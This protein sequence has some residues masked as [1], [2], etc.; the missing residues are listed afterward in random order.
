[1][2]AGASTD[3]WC[4]QRT[5]KSCGPDIPTL[6]SGATRKRCHPRRQE[7]PVSGASTKETVRTIA[8]GMPGGSG[9]TVVTNLCAFLL[10]TQGCGRACRPAFPAPS[11][12][13]KGF[14]KTR[15]ADF[16]CEN[17]EVWLG[18]V[19]ARSKATKQ[20]RL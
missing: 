11:A 6:I 8:R 13:G 1:M 5:A 7:S 19:I 17:A 20:S 16:A 15:G 12:M 10:C 9:V 14:Y 4:G 18:R 2:D 3:E